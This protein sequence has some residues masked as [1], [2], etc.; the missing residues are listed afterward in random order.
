LGFFTPTEAGTGDRLLRYFISIASRSLSSKN[1]GKQRFET[2]PTSGFYN[3]VVAQ[4]TLRFSRLAVQEN[5][6]K[7]SYPVLVRSIYSLI[8]GSPV[9]YLVLGMFSRTHGAMLL[10]LPIVLLLSGRWI[11]SF[12]LRSS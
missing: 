11:N 7:S 8:L 1:S 10:T 5:F 6:I 12:G 4:L 9:I 3:R 2:L